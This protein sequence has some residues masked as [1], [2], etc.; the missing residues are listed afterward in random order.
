MKQSAETEVQGDFK[1]SPCPISTTL[2]ILGDKWTLLVIRDLFLGKRLYGEFI[3][4]PEG[5]PTNI[6]ADR[7]RRLET[8]GLIT[9]EA[10]QERPVRY[11]YSLTGKGADLLPV[12][13]EIMRWANRHIP[14]TAKPPA[15][16]MAR[17]RAVRRE[18][19]G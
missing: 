16:V 7:L 11:A 3:D 6:L 18:A 1:R 13:T 2:D 15:K 14:G 4:S 19:S 5:I 8:A 12:L 9:K 10:Y 17:A